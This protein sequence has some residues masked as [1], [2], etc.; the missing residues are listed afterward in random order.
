[1]AIDLVLSLLLALAAWR[2]LATRII[3]D[4][5]AAVIAVIGIASRA[6]LGWTPLCLSLA[7]ASLLFGV[8]LA[9]AM[10]GWLG[11][12]D[13]KLAGAVALG[14]PPAATWDFLVA[15]I[16][17]GGMLG[18]GYLMARTR[19]PRLRPAG[20]AHPFA[21]ILAVEAWRLRRGGPLPYGTAIAAGGF[22]VL[23]AMQER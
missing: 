6:A 21:R 19:T 12:G 4:P 7:V 2:D 10:R 1:M 15:T 17:A 9:L 3:P 16:L 11:G 8:L 13:V 22:L 18:C 14:L 20:V 5:I 23:L